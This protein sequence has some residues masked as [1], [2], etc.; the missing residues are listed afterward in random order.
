MD[1]SP[2]QVSSDGEKSTCLAKAREGFQM[3]DGEKSGKMWV[4]KRGKGRKE[5]GDRK[6]K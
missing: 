3:E 1:Y 6:K 2:A 5:L 4:A